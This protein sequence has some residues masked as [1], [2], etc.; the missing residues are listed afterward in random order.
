MNP[1]NDDLQGKYV[2]IS[3]KYYKGDIAERVFFC[4][5]GFGCSPYT[6]G[7]AVMG[8]F[9]FD[10]SSSRVE[11]YEIERFATSFEVEEAKE[12]REEAIKSNRG[13][14]I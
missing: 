12:L 1:L 13:A 11:S 8:N 7:R 3:S 6:M 14:F 5:G 9:V 4:K 10:G 2:V